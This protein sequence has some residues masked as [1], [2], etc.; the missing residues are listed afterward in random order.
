MQKQHETAV[1]VQKLN[2]FLDHDDQIRAYIADFDYGSLE[3]LYAQHQS[4]TDLEYAAIIEEYAEFAI[5]EGCTEK[6][7]P[8]ICQ[9]FITPNGI[10]AEEILTTKTLAVSLTS[11]DDQTDGGFLNMISDELKVMYSQS[12]NTIIP[13]N[14]STRFDTSTETPEELQV[15][16]TTDEKELLGSDEAD[17][18]IFTTL[19]D[20]EKETLI[21]LDT[22][23]FIK[24]SIFEESS[25]FITNFVLSGACLLYLIMFALY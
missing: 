1:E 2:N 17:H 9:E 20:V 5:P 6:E 13:E 8:Y 14:V 18:N 22:M 23:E 11:E 16:L 15:V 3:N 7:C 24:G 12:D 4:L 10:N 25:G 19:E 21:E